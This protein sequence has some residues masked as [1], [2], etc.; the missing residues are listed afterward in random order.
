MSVQLYAHNQSTYDALRQRMLHSKKIAIVQCTGTGKSYIVAKLFEEFVGKKLFLSSAVN[1]FD[2]IEAIS[3]EAFKTSDM[4]SYQK[5]AIGKNADCDQL[6]YDLIVLDEFQRCGSPVWGDSVDRLLKNNPDAYVIG[7]TATPI[8]SS[9]NNKDMSKILFN[10]NLVKYLTL[11]EAIKQGIL[12]MPNYVASVYDFGALFNQVAQQI[13]QS[14]N[15]N[16]EKLK[17]HRQLNLAKNHIQSSGGVEH[18]LKKHFRI[19]KGKTLVFCKNIAHLKEMMALVKLWFEK[20]FP[21]TPMTIDAVHSGFDQN[22]NKKKIRNFENAPAS[23]IYLLFTVNMLNEGAH[24]FSIANVM[25]L[26]DTSS[27]TLYLQQL[28]RVLSAGSKIK[29]T[30]FDLVNNLYNVESDG[31]Y[32]FAKGLHRRESGLP[33]TTIPFEIDDNIKNIQDILHTITHSL[34]GE[35]EEGIEALK[36]F[37][38]EFGHVFV[39]IDYRVFSTGFRL[40]RWMANNRRRYKT[41]SLSKA[42]IQ[43]FLDLG[44]DI[45]LSLNEQKWQY[46]YEQLVDYYN[47][48]G[49]LVILNTSSC[50]DRRRL[51]FWLTQQ[52]RSYK[53]NALP[54]DYIEKLEDLGIYW[55]AI[56]QNFYPRLEVAIKAMEDN[57]SLYKVPDPLGS[58][59]HLGSW[60]KTT[61]TEARKGRL[62]PEKI[63]TLKELNII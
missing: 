32:I 35:F 30:V 38:Q 15:P 26:R 62:H 28:G 24:I 20:A 16:K 13:N 19:E 56:L 5:L 3:K 53:K 39:P 49:S 51:C 36:D 44:V 60:L 50:P 10:H 40:G 48:H 42:Q 33:K 31:M 8:R 52:R 12:P 29:P 54:S 2:Q 34:Y 41:K 57:I 55:D 59:I 11:E 27:Q 23:G 7:T 37:K 21:N 14:H 1:A 25:F 43:T 46:Y 4:M 18:L 45:S 58:C 47:K 61:K 9:D 6:T 17:L 22:T 63:K